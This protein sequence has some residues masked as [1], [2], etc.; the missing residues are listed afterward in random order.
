MSGVLSLILIFALITITIIN[1]NMV[2]VHA[3][4]DSSLPYCAT[5]EGKDGISVK[6]CSVNKE[7][8]DKNVK[9]NEI[10]ASCKDTN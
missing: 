8:C 6:I 1:L 10:S 2:I 7:K 9:E 3:E 5:G 4:D